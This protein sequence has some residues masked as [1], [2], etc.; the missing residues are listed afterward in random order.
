MK[1]NRSIL[2]AGALLGTI[3]GAG[4]F[5]IPFIFSR[6]GVFVSFI[7]FAVLFFVALKIHLYF[8][9]VVLRTKEKMRLVGYANKYLGALAGNLVSFS[10]LVGVSGSLLAYIIISGDFLHLV[11][12]SFLTPPQ[13]SFLIWAIL[14]LFVFLGIRSV[15]SVGFVMNILLFGILG[16]VFFYCIPHI[17]TANYSLLGNGFSFLPFGVFLFSL[18]GWNAVPEIETIL[19]NK[20]KL[21][22]IIFWTLLFATI[23]YFF[24]GL[25]LSGVSGTATSE[26][27][28]GGLLPFLGN[29]ILRLGG[30]MGFLAVATSFLILANYLKNTLVLDF[31]FHYLSGFLVASL[32]PFVLYLA[33]I[34]NFLP[35]IAFVGSFVGLIDGVIIILLHKKAKLLGNRMPEY[36]VPSSCFLFI[37]IT[38]VL[39]VGAMAQ[40]LSYLKVL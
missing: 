9:E 28:F 35:I 38:A 29:G 15:V 22:K 23:F 6:S 13:F 34:R 40:T 10:I 4:V 37:F 27:A 31:K 2:A 39:V 25:I 14:S 24:F 26:E 7:Y 21:K 16:F 8:S 18:V 11:F 36:S 1:I 33:G 20:K 30:A 17:E 5:G 12:P 32:F 19:I 3:V